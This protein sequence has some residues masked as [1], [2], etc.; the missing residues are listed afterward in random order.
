MAKFSSQSQLG[1][2]SRSLQ[3]EVEDFADFVS[4]CPLLDGQ[5]IEDVTVTKPPGSFEDT[6]IGH[7]LG[8]DYQ[9]YLIIRKNN[10]AAVFE[11]QTINAKKSSTIILSTNLS[12]KVSIWI[13]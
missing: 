10:A 12:C 7:S 1:E 8:R 13:F 4:T 9:G 11:S 2:D 6:V 5:L 3:R